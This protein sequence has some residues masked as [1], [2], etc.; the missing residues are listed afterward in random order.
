MKS[1]GACAGLLSQLQG[2]SAYQGRRAA[3]S[4][5][6]ARRG[7]RPDRAPRRQPWNLGYGVVSM[8]EGVKPKCSGDRRTSSE[9]INKC[10]M[11]P[12]KKFRP[13]G[14]NIG[15]SGGHV[16]TYEQHRSHER[17]RADKCGSTQDAVTHNPEAKRSR[18]EGLG[19]TLTNWGEERT[20]AL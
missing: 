13:S 1:G 10:V 20:N 6:L 9:Q 5:R 8:S 19:G 2:G 11:T 15:V 4:G 12:C 17:K 3:A 7:V 14:H 16:N 18:R